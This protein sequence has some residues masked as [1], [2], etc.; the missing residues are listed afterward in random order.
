M[1]KGTLYLYNSIDMERI[2]TLLAKNGYTLQVKEEEG[3]DAFCMEY[4]VDFKRK[5]EFDDE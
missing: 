4:R 5:D 3:L 1:I 2:V